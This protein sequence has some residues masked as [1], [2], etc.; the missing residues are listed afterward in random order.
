MT[1]LMIHIRPGEVCGSLLGSAGARRRRPR[2]ALVLSG[3]GCRLASLEDRRV[4]IHQTTTEP[5]GWSLRLG[6]RRMSLSTWWTTG[7]HV[8]DSKRQRIVPCHKCTSR[9]SCRCLEK[10]WCCGH[11][12]GV[13]L[14]N[15][16]LGQ[17]ESFVDCKQC[18]FSCA[19]T[20]SG[21]FVCGTL[22]LCASYLVVIESLD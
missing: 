18:C 4:D 21:H 16:F 20:S 3:I 1:H 6:A 14:V 7:P 5:A 13:N 9:D 8:M 10:A 15:E 12:R 11:V 2:L 17:M 22:L 19:A